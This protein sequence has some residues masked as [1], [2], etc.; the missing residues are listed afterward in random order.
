MLESP[1]QLA[2]Q[3]VADFPALVDARLPVVVQGL[4]LVGSIAL[5][6]FRPGT[7]DVDFVASAWRPRHARPF[8]RDSRSLRIQTDRALLRRPVSALGAPEWSAWRGFLSAGS[9]SS[10]V[11]SD[12]EGGGRKEVVA[13]DQPGAR[14]SPADSVM[15][16]AA[17]LGSPRHPLAAD[18]W[19]ALTCSIVAG[20]VVRQMAR[21]RPAHQACHPGCDVPE[22][23]DGAAL[24]RCPRGRRWPV[25]ARWPD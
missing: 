9:R 19:L 8:G 16:R 17:D 23:V 7:S 10:C 24:A 13:A 4:Y 1:H 2:R 21:G 18:R 5:D 14:C 22:Q 20:P 6:D 3:L 25:A 15:S 12:L 11:P